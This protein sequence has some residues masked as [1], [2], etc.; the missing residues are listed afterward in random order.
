[1]AESLVLVYFEGGKNLSYALIEL[2]ISKILFGFMEM[3][4]KF[5]NK[6]LLDAPKSL[7]SK[8]KQ[9]M[10]IT[11][12]I[13]YYD[14]NEFLNEMTDFEVISSLHNGKERIF[15]FINTMAIP[16]YRRSDQLKSQALIFEFSDLHEMLNSTNF[17]LHFSNSMG[18][19]ETIDNLVFCEVIVK[20]H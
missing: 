18:I 3:A 1:M 8:L 17:T 14:I 2:S 9:K 20:D 11:P 12:S 19:K 6:L 10:T 15:Y 16:E 13:E 7:K 5:K 4:E